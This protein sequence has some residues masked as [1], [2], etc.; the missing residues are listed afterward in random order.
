[1]KAVIDRFEGHY[2]ICETESGKTIE[3]DISMVPPESKE[4]DILVF[5]K[6]GIHIDKEKTFERRQ[7]I[8]KLMND[9]WD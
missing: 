2:V 8:E 1:M 4:G 6:D 5:C 7:R 3:I 9:L